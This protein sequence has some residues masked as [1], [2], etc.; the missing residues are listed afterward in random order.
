MPIGKVG[1]RRNIVI[2]QA[3]CE[4]VGLH[5]GDYVEVEAVEGGVLI[6][7]KKL[8]DTAAYLDMTRRPESS[9]ETSAF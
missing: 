6:R 8:V 7:P 9:R 1:K 4:Q 5:E 2:P 3:I